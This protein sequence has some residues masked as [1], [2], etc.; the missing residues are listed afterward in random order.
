MDLFE[1]IEK[2]RSIRQ[3]KPERFPDEAVKKALEAALLAPNSSNVQAWH[4]YWIKPESSLRAK[5]VENCLSQA[6]A[7]TSS[8]L[9]VAVSDPALWRRSHQPLLDFLGTIKVPS[10]VLTYYKKIIPLTYRWG[11]FNILAPLKWMIAHSIG[12]I[13]PMTRGPNSR[14][15]LQEVTI[16]STALACENFV[17]AISAQGGSSCMMEGFDECRMRSLLKLS[18]SARIAMV[19][20]V[21][22]ESERGTWGPRFRLPF[23]SV[24]TQCP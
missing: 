18:S 4:F 23:D 6:A 1:A 3:F 13:R 10:M 20:G 17:L 2:R 22:Y 11:I 15:D 24:V 7:R 12:L 14:R 5:V 8:H 19:I 16:K 21:G 9:I